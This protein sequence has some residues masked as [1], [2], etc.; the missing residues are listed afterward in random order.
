MAA[1]QQHDGPYTLR[2]GHRLSLL[3]R[4]GVS[5]IRKAR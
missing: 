1:V 2:S 4:V 3:G 5:A